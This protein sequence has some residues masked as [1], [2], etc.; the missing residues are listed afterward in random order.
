M[1]L[2]ILDRDGVINYDSPDFIKSPDEWIPIPGSL[3][4]ISQLTQ[5]GFTIVVATNQS[6]VARGLYNEAMLAS[7]HTKMQAAVTKL[8]G[9]IEH[10]FY[11]PHSPEDNCD[12]R[13]P[14]TGL[15]KQITAALQTPLAGVP[16]IGDTLRDIQ[17]AQAM[18]CE[19]ILVE[20]G[21]GKETLAANP[22]LT[23]PV[24]ADLAAATAML[25]KKK[26]L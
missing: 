5:A 11:C 9:R 7:I 3:E 17:A 23:V 25:L 10:I 16:A 21:Q 26:D 13:K 24:F 12:C 19:A 15:F 6:G 4:A 20:T 8:G 2:I 18:G 1:K 22:H 14:K